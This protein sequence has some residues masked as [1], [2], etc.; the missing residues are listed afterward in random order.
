MVILGLAACGNT[1][2]QSDTSTEDPISI[3]DQED[4]TAADAKEETDISA[5][6]TDPETGVNILVAYFSRTGNTKPMAEYAAEYYGADIYEILAKDP[7]TAEDIDYSDSESRTTIEQNDK[8]VR[9][10][11][12]G[13]VENMDQ[14]DVI[15]LAYPIWWNRRRGS[16]I[17]SW[18]P[19]IFPGRPSF[20]SAHQEA[21]T[22]VPVMMSFMAWSVIPSPGFRESASLQAVPMKK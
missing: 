9:P 20:L 13:S 18:N 19:M 2:G 17:L 15:V 7:Y 22:L 6:S 1:D 8:S 3:A 16:L 5:E 10:E 14:Y 21:V 4:Q 12:D 11:I